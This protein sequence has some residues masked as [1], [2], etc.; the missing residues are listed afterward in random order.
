MNDHN[1]PSAASEATIT[2]R[3]NGAP[4][5]VPEDMTVEALLER[6]GHD[7][8]GLAVAVN[9]DVVPR[10]SWPAT[11]LA[12]GASVEILAAAQGG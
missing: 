6:L 5:R 10:S 3:V 2:I 1:P 8:R 7:P 11:Q 9:A 4:Q 12:D